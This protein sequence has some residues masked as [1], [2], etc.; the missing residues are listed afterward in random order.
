MKLKG[1]YVN[2][3]P[4]SSLESHFISNFLLPISQEQSG[5]LTFGTHIVAVVNA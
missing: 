3:I 2:H 5:R 4:M 1:K